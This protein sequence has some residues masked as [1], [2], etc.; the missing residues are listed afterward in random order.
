MNFST[1][2][3]CL[4]PFFQVIF[5]SFQTLVN[6]LNEFNFIWAI[7]TPK[8][9]FFSFPVE[10]PDN[11]KGVSF[12]VSAN[13]KTQESLI[14]SNLLILFNQDLISVDLIYW[15]LPR[16]TIDDTVSHYATT[17]SNQGALRK[18]LFSLKSNS[19]QVPSRRLNIHSEINQS[20]SQ[21]LNR[22]GK[23]IAIEMWKKWNWKTEV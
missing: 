4:N 16:W 18:I 12:D 3:F 21:I 13:N 5:M 8:V 9:F 6:I 19:Q 17:I 14:R 15:I 23:L 7:K 1:P 20:R 11:W 10:T 22:N 2:K